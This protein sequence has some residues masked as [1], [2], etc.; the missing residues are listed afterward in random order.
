M[1]TRYFTSPYN[2]TGFPGSG[3]MKHRISSFCSLMNNLTKN[4]KLYY[5]VL[6]FQNRPEFVSFFDDFELPCPSPAVCFF[7]LGAPT[8][9]G[10][11]KGP[12]QVWIGAFAYEKFVELKGTSGGSNT[13][14]MWC[15]EPSGQPR[16]PSW[17][18]GGNFSLLLLALACVISRRLCF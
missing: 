18:G 9:A 15:E 2:L 3:F 8:D 13:G 16:V 17:C 12:D 10:S 4:Q 1:Y 5:N 7:L 6:F 11:T 14:S